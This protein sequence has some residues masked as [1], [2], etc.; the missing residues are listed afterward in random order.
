MA[1]RNPGATP[2][3]DRVPPVQAIIRALD[4]AKFKVIR[5]PAGDTWVTRPVKGKPS[6]EVT[7][8]DTRKA[9]S[10]ALRILTQAGLWH[11]SN[12]HIGQALDI[13]AERAEEE[14]ARP[15]HVRVAG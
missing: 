4:C 14:D 5:T 2:E 6:P 13:M 9:T 11:F 10:Q 7:R 12:T 1:R 15:V 8:Y 3:P